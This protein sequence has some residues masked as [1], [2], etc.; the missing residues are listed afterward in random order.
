MCCAE[1]ACSCY[2]KCHT[3][4]TRPCPHNGKTHMRRVHRTVIASPCPIPDRRPPGRRFRS[5]YVP[6]NYSIQP[7]P[8]HRGGSLR[9]RKYTHICVYEQPK[10]LLHPESC[11]SYSGFSESQ[12]SRAPSPSTVAV[13]PPHTT[14]RHAEP[15]EGTHMVR[16]FTL[17]SPRNYPNCGLH[18][19]T[20]YRPRRDLASRTLSCAL[21]V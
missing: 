18:L 1:E 10:T 12:A 11:R 16:P 2:L 5:T 7:D 20:R 13:E 15:P 19:A 4:Q 8:Q 14:Q 3:G 21:C 6:L 9:V 17:R